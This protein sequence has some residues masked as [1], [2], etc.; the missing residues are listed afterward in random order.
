MGGG[1]GGWRGL[2]RVD[3]LPRS[4][5]ALASWASLAKSESVKKRDTEKGSS[6]ALRG[7]S[8]ALR[9]VHLGGGHHH[10]GRRRVVEGGDDEEAASVAATAA[11]G[12]ALLCAAPDAKA[13]PAASDGH[14]SWALAMALLV[15]VLACVV[16]L[17]RG[18]AIC[19][20]TA[21]PSDAAAGRPTPRAG[22]G[23]AAAAIAAYN[24][25]VACNTGT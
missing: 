13:R 20:C 4:P 2:R 7:I 25:L 8:V 9:E 21:P 1:G 17:G 3:S 11:V 23:G 5:V 18:P 15:L 22:A 6:R 10:A 14:R 24:E 19:Y 12:V 16:A